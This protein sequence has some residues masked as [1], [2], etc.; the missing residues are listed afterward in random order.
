MSECKF[1]KALETYKFAERYWGENLTDEDKQKLGKRMDDYSVAIVQWTWWKK[2]G[3]KSAGR[4]V[5][6]RRNG[7][8][9]RLNFCPECGKDLRKR[10][11][12]AKM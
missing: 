2:R 11:N 9:Y 6:Y 1:C 10:H 7:V 3:R 8:G 5:G 12:N 4:T